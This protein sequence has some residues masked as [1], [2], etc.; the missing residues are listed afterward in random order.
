MG[1]CC[2]RV[3]KNDKD[4]TD[5]DPENEMFKQAKITKCYNYKG[6]GLTQLKMGEQDPVPN[7]N[8]INCQDNLLTSLP[9]SFLSKINRLKK[10][11]LSNNKFT[12]ID[13]CIF[14]F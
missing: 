8:V 9:S 10:L 7:V 11:Y 12:N 4:E 1:A 2:P 5:I 14:Y 3:S 13:L 6:K